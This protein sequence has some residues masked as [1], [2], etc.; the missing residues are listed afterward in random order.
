MSQHQPAPDKA[1]QDGLG[2]L[3]GF[4]G[5]FAE[6]GEH[7]KCAR[8]FNLLRTGEQMKPEARGLLLDAVAVELGQPRLPDEIK[9]SLHYDAEPA[10]CGPAVR[11]R[12]QVVF[13]SLTNPAQPDQAYVAGLAYTHAAMR[14][15]PVHFDLPQ[16]SVNGTTIVPLAREKF[17]ARPPVHP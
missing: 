17:D 13:F 12:L 9:H 2:A 10:V 7:Y 1:F 16:G 15:C 6:I 4:A 5:A 14:A 8:M 3:N 11:D